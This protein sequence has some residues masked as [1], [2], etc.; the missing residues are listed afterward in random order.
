MGYNRKHQINCS[1]FY[2]YE[3]SQKRK[4]LLRNKILVGAELLASKFGW[5]LLSKKL[6][7]SYT[8]L[9]SSFFFY[10]PFTGEIIQL[11][12][13]P[14]EDINR[15]T[16]CTALVFSDC[17]IFVINLLYQ[18]KKFCVSTFSLGDTTWSSH[19]LYDYYGHGQLIYNIAYAKGVF[20]CAFNAYKVM[21]AYNPALHEWKLHPYPSVF[22]RPYI[23]HFYLIESLDDGNL[24]LLAYKYNNPDW[25]FR[26]DLSQMKWFRIENFMS[27]Q[28]NGDLEQ[29]EVENLNNRILF[30]SPHSG[31]SLPAA[32]ASKL[33]N[34]IHST[35][36]WWDRRCTSRGGKGCTH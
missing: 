33:A 25:V 7:K 16:F 3:P 12:E 19:W 15:A 11:L 2:L 9:S 14:M 36:F 22:K 6:S 18:A 13:L 34:T 29:V 30:Y 27:G 32:E 26:F 20:Y 21:G 1:L 31:I 17:V 4:Y 5:L 28:S 10:S 24:I 23:Y 8:C 35:P